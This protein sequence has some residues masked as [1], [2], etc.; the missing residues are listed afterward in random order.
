[1]YVII[2][3]DFAQATLSVLCELLLAIKLVQVASSSPNALLC[4]KIVA[5]V[6]NR[7]YEIGNL[8]VLYKI[9]DSY[10]RR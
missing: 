9:Q 5:W 10:S 1:M 4:M 3:L 7:H 8:F 2:E 6:R